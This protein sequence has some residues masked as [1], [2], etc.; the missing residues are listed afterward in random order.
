MSIN[1][2]GIYTGNFFNVNINVEQLFN[3]CTLE[4]IYLNNDFYSI[5]QEG[6]AN[7]VYGKQ[8]GPSIGQSIDLSDQY[9]YKLRKL[10]LPSE[11]ITSINDIPALLLIYKS[12]TIHN[13]NTQLDIDNINLNT[14]PLVYSLSSYLP[15]FFVEINN[16][17]NMVANSNFKTLNQQLFSDGT[18]IITVLQVKDYNVSNL[19]IGSS[20]GTFTIDITKIHKILITYNSDIQ[21]SNP[22]IQESDET[23]SLTEYV[24]FSVLRGS[25]IDWET[26]KSELENLPIISD[27]F[28]T[29]TTG[30]FEK[31]LPTF[32]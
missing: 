23:V 8:Q 27:R 5:I 6:T 16:N 15:N 7:Y 26:M 10:N 4:D 3:N 28:S 29:Y 21:I 1:E 12:T 22:I 13:I 17:L 20:G 19:Y 18:F 11:E 25:N 9:N 32:I 24:N 31:A 2:N 30:S 14:Y